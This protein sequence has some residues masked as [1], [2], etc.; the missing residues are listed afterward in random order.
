MGSD[1]LGEMDER[2]AHKVTLKA[3]YLDITEVTNEEYFKCVSAGVCRPH[4]KSSARVNKVGEDRSFRKPKQPISA[5]SWD[6]SLAYCKWVGKRLPTEAEWEKASRG[7]DGRLY[8]WG[9]ELGTHEHAVFGE[10][11][12]ADV[13]SRPKGKGPYGHMD[14]A[15]N[16]WEW[17][18]DFYDPYAY[19]RPTADKGIHGTCEQTMEAFNELRRLGKQGFTGSNPIPGRCEKVLRGGAFNY[20]AKGLRS[21]N[22]VHHAANFQLVMSGFRCAKDAPEN[23]SP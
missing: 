23:A 20:H 3:Y 2:P 16:V 18:D 17:V 21:S 12:T 5:I 19:R 22:R 11:T 13:G 10:A 14:L 15:G 9:N 1:D 4:D 7:T 8:P 6:D